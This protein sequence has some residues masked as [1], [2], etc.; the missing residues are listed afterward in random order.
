[1]RRPTITRRCSPRCPTPL[2]RSRSSIS[3]TRT[4]PTGYFT[5]DRNAA[6][7]AAWNSYTATV[8]PAG[9]LGQDDFADV[10]TDPTRSTVSSR[11]ATPVRSVA[12]NFQQLND[13]ANRICGANSTF[14]VN[15]THDGGTQLRNDKAGWQSIDA[16][17]AHLKIS[18]IGSVRIRCRSRRQR[19]RQHHE[20]HD[21]SSV[22]GMAGLGG[23]RR[24]FQFRLHGQSDARMAGAGRDGATVQR[25]ARARRSTRLTA[26]CCPIR[27]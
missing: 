26:A 20:L 17:T 21:Q 2:T 16:S 1:M 27:K 19:Q 5:S 6:Q 11:I 12:P 4:L 14:T 23:L 25:R 9:T 10:V 15:V 24:L 22:R 13:R 3:P 8:T 7:L 18:C